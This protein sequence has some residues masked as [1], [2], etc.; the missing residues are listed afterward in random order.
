MKLKLNSKNKILRQEFWWV[1]LIEMDF[2]IL[3]RRSHWTVSF[4]SQAQYCGSYLIKCSKS[5]FHFISMRTF[6]VAS[7][8]IPNSKAFYP[9]R[10]VLIHVIEKSWLQAQQGPGVQIRLSK[11]GFLTTLNTLLASFS[12]F[13]WWQNSSCDFE[14]FYLICFMPRARESSLRQRTL[15]S[16]SGKKKP[17]SFHHLRFCH[18]HILGPMMMA[19]GMWHLP[20][21]RLNPITWPRILRATEVEE[22]DYEERNSSAS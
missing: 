16:A 1:L 3:L 5:S 2:Y 15:P 11:V 10:E 20:G 8:K 17:F 21:F 19:R 18:E 7:D 6:S 12:G 13:L 14:L 9:K 22:M 4:G